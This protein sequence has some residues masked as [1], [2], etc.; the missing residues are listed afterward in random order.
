[1]CGVVGYFPSHDP[2]IDNGN[3]FG[4]L[5]RESSIRGMHAYGIVSWDGKQFM[6]KIE[7]FDICEYKY[8]RIDAML[9]G[10][11]SDF[12]N[13][14][15]AIGHTRYST[16]GD[17]RDLRNNQPLVFPA[18]EYSLAFNG[19][20]DMR[21]KEEMEE[22][23]G[24][25]LM[26]DNDG[27]IAIAIGRL[28]NSSQIEMIPGTFAGVW[29]HREKLYMGRNSKRPLWC[30]LGEDGSIWV[31]STYDIFKRAGFWEEPFEVEANRSWEAN[32]I[33]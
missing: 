7:T 23:Y 26:Y 4:N 25:K 24:I 27:E 8:D 13:R 11:L 2:H 32:E 29:M 22:H 6:R 33:V 9:D 15:T 10:P 5:M 20:V 21:T 12:N 17:W 3:R 28:F 14:N 1:M 18:G 31:A 16:S 19:V 30:L